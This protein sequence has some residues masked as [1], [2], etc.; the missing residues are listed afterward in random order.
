MC[1][2]TWERFLLEKLMVAHLVNKLL[3]KEP[4][5]SPTCS[6]KTTIGPSLEPNELSP[7]SSTAFL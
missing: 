6:Q 2:T 4:E 5:V 1:L 3:F 7:H